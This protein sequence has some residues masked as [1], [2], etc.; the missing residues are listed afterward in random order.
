MCLI[1]FQ[2]QDHPR[3]KLVIAAN[4]DEFYKRP[5]EKAHFWNDDPQIL[6]G[7]DLMQMGTWLG[8]STSGRIAALTNFRDPSL[9]DANKRSRGAIVRNFLETDMPPCLFLESINAEDYTGFNLVAGTADELF[10][11]NNIDQKASAIEA[12]IHGLSNHFLDTPWPK[13]IKGKNYLER[14]LSE[15]EK[16]QLPDLFEILADADQA[17]EP[18]LP[19][20]GVGI[21][22]EKILSPMFI[23]TADY[24]TRSST[25]VLVDH[26]DHLTFAERV[27][28]NGVL[29]GE[30]VFEFGI[31]KS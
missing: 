5:T 10:Y 13:V 19:D 18:D 20:T 6:A 26:N 23:K 29:K 14:Y 24:G 25:V 9:P 17:A 1:N 27:Y 31:T 30:Q 21:E 16:V 8:V 4:R 3:Y 28:D 22:F 2:F 11:Y 12:G 7:R 15:H